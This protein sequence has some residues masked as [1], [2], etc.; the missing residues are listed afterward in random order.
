LPWFFAGEEE[1][2]LGSLARLLLKKPRAL[3]DASTIEE[4]LRTVREFYRTDAS[5]LRV[6]LRSLGRPGSFV[7]GHD[8]DA[9]FIQARARGTAE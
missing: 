5:P 4:K 8:R 6:A 3:Q 7:P 9:L 2:L 1:V